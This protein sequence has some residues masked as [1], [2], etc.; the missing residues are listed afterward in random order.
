L[1][2]YHAYDGYDYM[3]ENGGYFYTLYANNAVFE[4]TKDG[5][6]QVSEKGT[7]IYDN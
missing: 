4:M 7:W 2:K 5:N 3:F 1:H 6:V